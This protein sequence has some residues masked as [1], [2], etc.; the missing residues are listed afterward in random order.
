[1]Y[2]IMS[3]RPFLL[4]TVHYIFPVIWLGLSFWLAGC[5]SLL[6]QEPLDRLTDDNFYVDS[7]SA[8]A[9][10]TAC[11]APLAQ[12]G[13]YQYALWAI[14]DGLSDDAIGYDA[15]EGWNVPPN[16]PL[17]YKLWSSHYTGIHRCNVV[18]DKVPGITMRTGLKEQYMAEARFLRALYLYNLVRLFGDVPAPLSV[19]GQLGDLSIP[20]QPVAMVYDQIEQDLIWAQEKLPLVQRVEV[21]RATRGAAQSLL[22]S[23]YLTQGR[24]SESASL[25]A[26]VIS[27]NVY[28][29]EPRFDDNF[30]ASTKNGPESVFAVQFRSGVEGIGN[31]ASDFQGPAGLQTGGYET[32]P[33]TFDTMPP[34]PNPHW[35]G[36]LVQAFEPGDVRRDIS[37]SNYGGYNRYTHQPQ[38]YL[39]HKFFTGTTYNFKQSPVNY[40]V[41]RY[42]E[43]LLTLSESRNELGDI[44][45]A[46]QALNE[47]RQR[48]GLPL[49]S[50]LS[51]DQLR[52]AIRHERRVEL[53]LEAH[54]WF[55]L[56]RY[57]TATATLQ[58]QN[59]ARFLDPQR[60]RLPIPQLEI[61]RNSLLKQN[62]GY[63]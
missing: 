56:L 13:G 10:S 30:K 11:Y 24:W 42:A 27:S 21:G 46:T 55:D 25:A 7:A 39:G 8:N 23:V 41:I 9:A 63:Y 16:D 14:T 6:D 19:A 50:G 51:Q 36:G 32:N 38:R 45:G 61:D 43:V 54:R 26:R 18:I 58:A 37:V 31:W 60:E 62:P 29:L 59:P 35:T 57:G 44:T 33:P 22:A 3:H 40:P 2:P 15:F 5:N 20:R 52:K 48:A 49:V 17:V 28:S 4:K 1:M 34:L 12:E 47:L 53:C